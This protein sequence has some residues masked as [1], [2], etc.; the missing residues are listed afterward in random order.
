MIIFDAN[1]LISLSTGNENDEAFE[2]I[3]GLIRDSV[4][5]KSVIGVPAPAWAEF[6]CGVGSG[7][8]G[9]IQIL[10]KRSAIRILPFDEIAATELAAIDQST[11]A[12]GGKKGAS[13]SHWQKIKVDRQ[14]LAIARVL[15]AKTIYTEDADLIAEA[16]RIGQTAC[17]VTDIP[18]KPR[19]TKLELL[20]PA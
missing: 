9:V 11:R 16:K 4:E 5:R 17:R 7:T 10:K 1:V 13:R 3:S 8:P 6:L 14:I 20:E 15:D 19:Q 2:R 18:L 12:T